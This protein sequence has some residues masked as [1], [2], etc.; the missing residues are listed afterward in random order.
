MRA[1]VGFFLATPGEVTRDQLLRM[2]IAFLLVF[3]C[4]FGA[5]GWLRRALSSRPMVFFG[6]IS[7]GMYLWHTSV[8][9]EFDGYTVLPNNLQ[10]VVSFVVTGVVATASWFLLERPILT[11]VHGRTLSEASAAKRTVAS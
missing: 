7:Y 11:L 6:T 4:V 8:I 3:P 2:P 5:G 10:F 9:R 1:A